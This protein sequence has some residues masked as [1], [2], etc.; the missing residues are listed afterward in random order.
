MEIVSYTTA[1]QSYP[2]S[3][4]ITN[5]D[6][7][8]FSEERQQTN[9]GLEAVKYEDILLIIV[10]SMEIFQTDSEKNLFS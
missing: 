1:M 8:R 7:I 2:L 9:N 6:E 3:W 5:G 10:F 4:Y